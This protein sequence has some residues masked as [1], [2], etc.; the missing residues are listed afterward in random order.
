MMDSLSAYLDGEVSP[1]EAERIEGHINECEE[2]RH[3]LASLRQTS[4]LLQQLPALPVPRSFV[5]PTT[6]TASRRL[7][8]VRTRVY[9]G[10]QGATVL[11]ALLLVF[12]LV[13]DLVPFGV[14]GT[15]PKAMTAPSPTQVVSELA[16]A[17]PVLEKA[18]APTVRPEV[19]IPAEEAKA[20]KPGAASPAESVERMELVPEQTPAAAIPEAAEGFSADRGVVAGTGA[21]GSEVKAEAESPLDA[22]AIPLPSE[23]V[24]PE[25]TTVSQRQAG[26]SRAEIA[27]G[28]LVT[29][30]LVTT[31]VFRRHMLRT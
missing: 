8:K 6:A 12:V 17:E 31:I 2:C 9:Y 19:R 29:V 26:D 10:L 23:R 15:L 4:H 21:P 7:F 30:L 20:V 14:P 13:S 22:E 24:E 28:L 27:T 11:A 1:E 16:A 5:L 18:N 3:E 25:T